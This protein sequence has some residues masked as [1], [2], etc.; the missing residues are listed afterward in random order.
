MEYAVTC[1]TKSLRVNLLLYGNVSKGI[2]AG[3]K[4]IFKDWHFCTYQL[5]VGMTKTPTTFTN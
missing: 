4:K 3:L 5:K 1:L 2:V